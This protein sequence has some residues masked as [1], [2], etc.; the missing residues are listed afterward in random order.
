MQNLPEK[1]WH[2][3]AAREAVSAFESHENN[4]LP[5]PEARSRAERFGVNELTRATGLLK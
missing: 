3:L 4:G 5:E 2:S 1:A